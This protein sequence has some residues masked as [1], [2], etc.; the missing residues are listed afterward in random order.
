MTTTASTN[1]STTIAITK[2]YSLGQGKVHYEPHFAQG[3][4]LI[5]LD[6]PERQNAFSGKMMVEFHE[7][8]VRLE[9]QDPKDTV[10]IIVTGAAGK[11]FCA[12]LD[13]T[14]AQKHLREPGMASHVNHLMHDALSR[15]SRL[16]YITVASMAGPALG[17]GTEMITAF[18]YVCIAS[19]TFLRFVQTRMGVSSPWEISVNHLSV[20][21]TG[22]ARRLANSLGRKKA[23]FIL[24]SAPKI[25][26]NMAKELGLADVIVNTTRGSDAYNACLDASKTFLRGFI[27]DERTNERVTPG[28]V[29]GMKKL[30][31]RADLKEDEAFEASVL[32]EL[33]GLS[34][35]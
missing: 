10:A 11:A 19:T 28:A 21:D 27:F 26:A 1:D 8:V 13:L 16:P 32:Q 20:Y 4:G 33:A 23:L 18:D 9:K 14:F 5:T 35:I 17:G 31:V 7:I 29:R 34:K 3:I 12:G 2:L 24:G 22:G 30:I 15:F 6:N 25:D